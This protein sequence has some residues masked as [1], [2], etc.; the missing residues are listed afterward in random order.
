MKSWGRYLALVVGV[1]NIISGII[2][3]AAIVGLIYLILGIVM[4]VYLLGDVK[5]EF[6]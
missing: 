6:E 2:L 1:F 4:F 5:Y 3:I